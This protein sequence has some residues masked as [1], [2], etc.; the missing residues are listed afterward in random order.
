M[1][2][3]DGKPHLVARLLFTPWEFAGLGGKDGEEYWVLGAQ[4]LQNYYT[5]Y[6]FKQKRVGIVE[7]VSSTLNKPAPKDTLMQKVNVEDIE[8]IEPNTI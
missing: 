3:V 6:D 1:S 7:S 4:F 8:T 5:M 2:V